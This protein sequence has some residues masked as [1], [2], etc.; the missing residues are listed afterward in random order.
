METFAEGQAEKIIVQ[1][2]WRLH[3]KWGERKKRWSKIEPVVWDP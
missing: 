1:T 2:N 3:Y